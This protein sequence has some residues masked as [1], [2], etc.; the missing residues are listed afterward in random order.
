MIPTSFSFILIISFCLIGIHGKT[1]C[2]PCKLE[3]CT[4]PVGCYVGVVTDECGCCQV[5]ARSEGELCDMDQSVYKYGQCGEG[6][7]CLIPSGETE[8]ICECQVSEMVCGSDDRTH[9]TVCSLNEEAQRRGEPDKYNPPLTIEYWGP[10]KEPPVIISGPSDVSGPLGANLTLSCE[11]R[12]FPAPVITWQFVSAEGKTIS[13]PSDD[14]SVSIQ[15]RGGPEPLMVTGWA[16][17]MYLDPTY[18]GIYHCIASNSLGQ[19]YAF[20]GVGVYKNEL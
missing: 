20:A 3:E 15:M 1:E 7:N 10:C 12:G 18:I 17:I 19:A 5:C 11:A 8:S 9:P 14:Q 4:S 16:Q 6:L 13:L 2:E